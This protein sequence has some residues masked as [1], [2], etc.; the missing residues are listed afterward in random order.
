MPPRFAVDCEDGRV[1]VDGSGAVGF[2]MVVPDRKPAILKRQ[3]D[4]AV[5]DADPSRRVGIDFASRI[6]IELT[7]ERT[8][9]RIHLGAARLE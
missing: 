1:V 3:Y 4:D 8:P 7:P 2:F 6:G 9:V 5:F